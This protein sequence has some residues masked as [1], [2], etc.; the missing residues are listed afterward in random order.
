MP[1]ALPA[2]ALADQYRQLRRFVRARIGDTQDV[3]DIVQEVFYE[4]TVAYRLMQPVSHVAG[5]LLRVARNRIID[6]FRGAG[7]RNRALGQALDADADEVE[8]LLATLALPRSSGP[9]REYARAALADLLE[10]ALAEL[11]P[12]QRAAFV[13]HEIEGQSFKDMAAGTGVSVNTLLG[14]KHAAVRRLRALLRA[15]YDEFDELTD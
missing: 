5:W 15:A 13:A 3:E 14:R 9:E 4:L 8:P 1:K 10:E 11:P 7:V 2:A 6:R 12:E